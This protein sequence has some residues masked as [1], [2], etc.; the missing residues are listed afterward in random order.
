[1]DNEKSEQENKSK[2]NKISLN[3]D[4]R[5][6][7][8]ILIIIIGAMLAIW[9]PW[10]PEPSID[11]RTITVK[12]ETTI[13][14]EPDEFVF[15]PS[16]EFKNADKDVALSDVTKK[17][18][19]VIGNLKELG[20]QDEQIKSDS[21][22]YDYNYYYLPED[23]QN[24][25]TLRLTVKA[26]D[27]E[28]AQKIQ[29]YLI[30]TSPT[31]SISPIAGFSDSKRKELESQARDEATKDARSKAEQSAEN[32]GFKIGKVKSVED[33]TDFSQI[34]ISRGAAE[35]SMDTKESNNLSVQP[36]QDDFNYSVTVV[37]YLK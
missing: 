12:G 21:S 18:E 5:I 8:L 6:I 13:Q 34:G 16:Y 31:G 10:S 19:E 1:M 14:A 24:V 29:D 28:Q 25:Y 20:V 4:T 35:L 9:K 36:G 22:G 23:R 26:H 33:G 37:Y 7:I 32:L 17:S 3:L 11:G 2:T 27:R 30:T 15:Y